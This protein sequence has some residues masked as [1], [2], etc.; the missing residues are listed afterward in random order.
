MKIIN[1][2]TILF[3]L[4]LVLHS[5]A[6]TPTYTP[7]QKELEKFVE[8]KDARIGI[9]VI[10]D[11]KD[12]VAVNGSKAFPMLSVYKFPIAI[13]VADLCS[14]N[15]TDFNDSCLITRNELHRDTYSPMLKKYGD[16]DSTYVTLHEL[17]A[18]SLQQSDNNA[19]DILLSLFSTPAEVHNYIS[20]L[21]IDGITIRW[22]EN[23]M[24]KDTTLCYEN[25]A[26]PIAMAELFDLFDR[27]YNDALSTQLKTLMESCTTGTDRLAKPFMT[28][29][30]VIGHKTGT[31]DVTPAGRLMAVNDDGYV[32][33]PNKHRYTIAVFITDSG[34][35][36]TQTSALISSIS[37]IVSR[38]IL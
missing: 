1:P 20:G 23:D 32:H 17:L 16:V 6:S 5:C 36:M 12:T 4:S 8:G 14:K 38:H 25:S 27:E 21:P 29:N 7:L 37:E 2:A 18:Y 26:T 13:A 30:A 22:S 33:L 3:I 24:H 15:E 31:G 9:A 10:I 35:N 34:Y 19:S 28:T 11:S